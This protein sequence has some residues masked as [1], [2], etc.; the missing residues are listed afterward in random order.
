MLRPRRVNLLFA[1]FTLSTRF[2]L[3]AL[4]LP[5]L[6]SAL[7]AQG[8]PART[9]YPPSVALF[10]VA[11]DP[12]LYCRGILVEPGH[13]SMGIARMFEY[14]LPQTRRLGLLGLSAD[15]SVRYLSVSMDDSR[16]IP[17]QRRIATVHFRRTGEIEVGRQS[18]E[19]MRTD[20]GVMRADSVQQPQVYGLSAREGPQAV[21]LARH[22]AAR[23]H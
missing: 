16:M 21:A 3:L 1:R 17:T 2:A 5:L 4:L 7:G 13:R 8:S 9:V 18:W 11:P 12:S 6:A 23:C 22:L 20:A 14:Q 19:V 10:E 15:S